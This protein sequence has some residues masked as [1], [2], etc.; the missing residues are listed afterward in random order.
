MELWR[1]QST[2]S[3]SPVAGCREQIIPP[4]FPYTSGNRLQQSVF[5]SFQLI[6]TCT[7]FGCI[8]H[9]LNII[10]TIW[11][12]H[13]ANQKRRPHYGG[14]TQMLAYQSSES[15]LHFGLN[16]RG[17]MENNNNNK[18]RYSFPCYLFRVFTRMYPLH[19]NV[20]NVS[21]FQLNCMMLSENGSAYGAF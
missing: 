12:S 1:Y 14:C 7:Q 9:S 6:Q 21:C 5:I 10:Y 15:R 17:K 13:H 16:K 18:W 4:S 20:S 11:N 2:G 8:F 3:R 19:D